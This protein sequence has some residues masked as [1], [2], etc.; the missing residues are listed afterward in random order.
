MSEDET[1]LLVFSLI[2]ATIT[3]CRWWFIVISR[4]PFGAS[5]SIRAA[6]AVAPIACMLALL[7]ILKFFA[8]SDVR[9]DA[10]Y[11]LLYTVAGAA[12]IG[13]ARVGIVSLGLSLR[14][15]CIE[16]RNGPVTTVTCCA[17]LAITLCF[18]G[19]NIGDGPGWWVVIFC[20]ALATGSLFALWTTVQGATAIADALTI[21]RNASDAVRFGAFLVASGL[22]LGRSVAGS[23]ISV[24]ETVKDFVAM[25]WPAL[26]LCVV[27]LVVGHIRNSDRVAAVRAGS[28]MGLAIGAAYLIAAIAYVISLGWW[29]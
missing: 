16:R 17:M 23:W 3:W 15:D 4:A 11:L 2:I 28:A 8:A 26:V 19:A 5:T 9:D 14:D 29:T 27:E 18:G 13:L 21:E 12:W 7:G 24:A 10:R 1:A 25:A 20:A 22:I 6:L